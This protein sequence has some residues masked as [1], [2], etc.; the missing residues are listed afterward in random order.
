MTRGNR[1]VAEVPGTVRLPVVGIRPHPALRALVQ[2]Y[3]RVAAAAHSATRRLV[4]DGS[5]D[6]IFNLTDAQATVAGVAEPAACIVGVMSS[7]VIT[8]RAA[9]APLFGVSVALG[10]ANAFLCGQV[11]DGK[12]RI[13]D[14]RDVW[15]RDAE[16]FLMR[17]R[18]APTTEARVAHADAF[19]MRKLANASVPSAALGPLI[20]RIRRHGGGLAMRTLAKEI[21]VSGRVARQSLETVVRERESLEQRAKRLLPFD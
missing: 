19:L 16:E 12:N 10:A 21:G 17:L 6:L 8:E 20:A 14:L 3:F 9:G 15:G 2:Q 13:V 1:T 5:I 4:P 11:G 7:A 18:A